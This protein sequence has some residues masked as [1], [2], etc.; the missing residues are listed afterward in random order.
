MKVSS[1]LFSSSSAR[2]N[3]SGIMGKNCNMES[4]LSAAV[5]N[6][7]VRPQL[8]GANMKEAVPSIRPDQ[9]GIRGSTTNIGCLSYADK[10]VVDRIGHR[11][12]VQCKMHRSDCT[13]LAW[14]LILATKS[15]HKARMYSHL[16]RYRKSSL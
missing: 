11:L 8:V 3:S 12:K 1:A 2:F 4:S 16:P 14:R 7:F 13:M 6:N 15:M 10:C 9:S 5:L